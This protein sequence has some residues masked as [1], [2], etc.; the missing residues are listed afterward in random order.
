VALTEPAVVAP[1]FSRHSGRLATLILG[2]ALAML[3]GA[4]ATRL[5]ATPP[6]NASRE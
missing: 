6:S 5:E 4:L 2:L 1:I 3:T